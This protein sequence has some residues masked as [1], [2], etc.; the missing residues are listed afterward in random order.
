MNAVAE[1]VRAEL[2]TV[3]SA[4]VALFVAD[5]AQARAVRRALVYALC[6]RARILRL[7][8]HSLWLT[9][10]NTLRRV[11]ICTAD[12]VRGVACT[13]L[14]VPEPCPEAVERECV[15]PA[16][17]VRGVAVERYVAAAN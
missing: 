12:N 9:I 8:D 11:N 16:R 17:G 7:N 14:L 15:S 13:L 4:D 6:H 3:P 2:E 10:D 1:R 5:A